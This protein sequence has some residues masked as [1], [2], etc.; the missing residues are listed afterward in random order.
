MKRIARWAAQGALYAAF[1][2]VLAVFSHWPVY[3]HLGPDRAVVKVSLSHQGQRLGD[4]ETL[5][6]EELAKLPPNMRAPTRCP[7]ERSPLL[8][9][10]DIDGVAAL[11]QGA[12]PSGLSRDGP[13]SIYRRIEVAAGRHRIAV[14]FE[15]DAQSSGFDH[16]RE[17]DVTLAPAEV[18]VIDFD[19]ASQEIVFQ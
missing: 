14:R 11:R 7:R 12:A 6:P 10:V 8:V 17:Q 9:E 15:D 4:C 3:R 16:R 2:A 13:A 19:S 1:A 18:L 5:S